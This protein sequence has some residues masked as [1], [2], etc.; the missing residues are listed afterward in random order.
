M[1]REVRVLVN[2][3][4]SAGAHQTTFNDKRLTSGVYLYRLEAGGQ[5]RTGVMSLIP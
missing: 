4:V 3:T 2:R 1:G 5:T